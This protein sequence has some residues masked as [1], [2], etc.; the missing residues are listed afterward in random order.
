MV[1]RDELMNSR[2]CKFEFIF[3]IEKKK[4]KIVKILLNSNTQIHFK[5]ADDGMVFRDW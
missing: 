4:K 2:I 1:F 3:D 5:M